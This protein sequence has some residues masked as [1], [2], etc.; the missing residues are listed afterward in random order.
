MKVQIDRKSG[1]SLHQ[2]LK[3]AIEH[4]IYFGEMAAGTSLPSIRDMA[5][6]AQVAPMTVTKVY[7]EL[8]AAGLIET[9]TGSGTLVAQT[10]LAPMTLRVWPTRLAKDK[11]P[12]Q[13]LYACS[14]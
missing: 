7:G 10:A 13:A 3:S 4:G 5:A 6:Q 8:K 14:G 1:F 12:I 11:M 2:Q 9:K